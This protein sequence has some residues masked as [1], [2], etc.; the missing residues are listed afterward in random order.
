LANNVKKGRA[1]EEVKRV[2]S[3]II[4]E[5][6]DPRIPS[7]CTVVKA[8]VSPDMKYAKLYVSFL[9]EYDEKEVRRGLKAASGYM[10]KRLGES[11]RSRA[12]PELSF[13]FDHSVETGA[14]IEKLLR[15]INSDEGKNG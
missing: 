8:D 5:I 14:R 15:E 9:G 3:D 10:R 6:K 11:L 2:M 13:E 1:S 7:F 12:V 4:R